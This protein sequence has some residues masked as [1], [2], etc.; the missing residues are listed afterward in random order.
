[1]NGLPWAALAVRLRELLAGG[2]AADPE[3]MRKVLA[4]VEG[5]V[6]EDVARKMLGTDS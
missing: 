2:R 3:A 6:A 4:Y 1:M 5:K